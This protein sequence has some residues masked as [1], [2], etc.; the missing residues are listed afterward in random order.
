MRIMKF[1]AIKEI[2]FISKLYLEKLE[3]RQI[4]WKRHPNQTIKV[5]KFLDD[6]IK[7]LNSDGGNSV[8]INVE[9]DPFTNIRSNIVRESSVNTEVVVD[10]NV[11]E[12]IEEIQPEIPSCSSDFVPNVVSRP[13]RV[14][15]AP[16]RLNL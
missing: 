13:K 6:K 11:K 8:S 1:K 3:N 10:D 4:V 14:I 2:S 12:R 5:G 9:S 16:D 15:K 7:E